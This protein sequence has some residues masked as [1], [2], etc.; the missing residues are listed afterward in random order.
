MSVIERCHVC[1]TPLYGEFCPTCNPETDEQG[2]E[3]GIPEKDD[4]PARIIDL[5]P[6]PEGPEKSDKKD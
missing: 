2:P 1:G 3:E 4:R 5:N 6:R